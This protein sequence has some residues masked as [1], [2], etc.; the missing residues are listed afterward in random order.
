MNSC[1]AT[2]FLRVLLIAQLVFGAVYE[3]MEDLPVGRRYDYIIVGAGAA[4]NVL[5]NRLSENPL[6]NVLVLEAGISNTNIETLQ[7]PG[8]CTLAAS[9][10]SLWDWNFTTTPQQALNGRAIPYPRGHVLGGSTSINFMV[11]T[12]ASKG[13]WDRYAKITGDDGWSWNAIQPYIRK[14]ERFVP[15]VD[16]HNITGQFNPSV[17][18]FT[19]INSVSLPGFPEPIDG[20]VIVTTAQLSDQ[21]PFNLDMNSGNHLGIGWVQSTITH[22][23]QRSSSA[24]SYL[25]TQVLSRSNLDVLLHARVTR[26]IK[27]SKKLGDQRKISARSVEF[28]VDGTTAGPTHILTANREVVLSAGAVLTPHVLLH[29]GIG[30]I[31]LLQSLGITPLLNLPGVGQNLTDHPAVANTWFVNGT[32]TLDNY[33]RNATLF[34]QTLKQWEDERQGPFVDEPI[35]HAGW[36]RLPSELLSKALQAGGL[37]NDPAA[38]MTAHYELVVTVN[39]FLTMGQNGVVVGVTPPTGNYLT[40]AT[41][42]VSPVSRGSLVLSSSSPFDPP[43]IDVAFLQSPFDLFVLKES[44]RSAAKFLTAPAWADYVMQ[45][46]TVGLAEALAPNADEALTNYVRAQTQTFFHPVSTAAMSPFGASWGVVDPDLR[47]KNVDGVRVVDASVFPVIPAAHTQAPVYI[48]AERA[49][50]LIKGQA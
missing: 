45:P 35:N 7:V 32:D 29:S 47:L 30:N 23:G 13:D 48:I 42:V 14:N 40:V 34:A 46:F 37:G 4:G 18:S 8:L 33:V 49:A 44:V 15:P 31:T 19:G 3:K 41:A 39:L 24:V 25:N 10:N 43:K 26:L 50:D 22:D 12:R 6:T 11:Y 21:Y 27:T 1:S 2:L 28:V 9:Q 38:T 17:H 5:A 36:L 16:N 20:R